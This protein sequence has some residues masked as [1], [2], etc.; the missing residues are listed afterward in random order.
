MYKNKKIA[1]VVPAYNEEILIESVIASMA[2]YIDKIYVVDDAST[3]NTQQIICDLASQNRKVVLIRH[4]VNMGVGA[5]IASGYRRALEDNIDIILDKLDAELYVND[6]VIA[7]VC[8]T[9]NINVA[10]GEEKDF[11]ISVFLKM[12]AVNDAALISMSERKASYRVD[13]VAYFNT[14]FGAVSFSITVKEVEWTAPD[15][16]EIMVDQI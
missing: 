16:K 13:G 3:D 15:E 5:A 2:D 12:E 11:F 9:N 14:I 4:R 7:K 6:I 8:N 1:V 10:K